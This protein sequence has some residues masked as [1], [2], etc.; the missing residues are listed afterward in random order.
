[1]GSMDGFQG[2]STSVLGYRVEKSD[3]KVMNWDPPKLSLRCELTIELGVPVANQGHISYFQSQTASVLG[4]M[5][6]SN[7]RAAG[8]YARS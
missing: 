5:L 6:E 1:M 3:I 2:Y 7:R 8:W 4:Y